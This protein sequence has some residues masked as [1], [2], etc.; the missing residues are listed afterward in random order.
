VPVI[1]AERA[2]LYRRARAGIQ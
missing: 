2:G 1:P